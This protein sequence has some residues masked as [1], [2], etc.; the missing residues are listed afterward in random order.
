MKT[1][2]KPQPTSAENLA[3]IN[4]VIMAATMQEEMT[5]LYCRWQDEKEYEDIADYGKRL[6][7]QLPAPFK[8]VKMTKRPFGFHFTIGTDA[9]YSCTQTARSF[10]WKREG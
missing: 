7:S 5:Y 2:T 10:G 9:V 4:K 6:V 8:L 3:L 1:L